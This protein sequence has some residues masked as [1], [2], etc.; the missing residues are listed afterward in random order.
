LRKIDL[1]YHIKL[2]PEA[3]PALLT[4]MASHHGEIPEYS[5]RF[6]NQRIDDFNANYYQTWADIPSFKLSEYWAFKKLQEH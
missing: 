5:I 1:N 2:G 3:Y 6:L 4:Y